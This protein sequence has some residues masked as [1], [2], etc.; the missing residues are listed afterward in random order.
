MF[1]NLMDEWKRYQAGRRCLWETKCFDSVRRK[2]E[3]TMD[4]Q[5]H[6]EQMPKRDLLIRAREMAQQRE[7]MARQAASHR[8]Y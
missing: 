1:E 2:E 4:A 6:Y 3:K 8:Y 7:V 5:A